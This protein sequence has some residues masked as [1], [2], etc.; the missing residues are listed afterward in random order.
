M[1]LRASGYVQDLHAVQK[2]K[3]L[4]VHPPIPIYFCTSHACEPKLWSA[5]LVAWRAIHC[6][7]YDCRVSNTG[8]PTSV[9]RRR[10]F[11]KHVTRPTSHAGCKFG[12]RSTTA[13]YMSYDLTKFDV[14]TRILAVYCNL[15]NYTCICRLRNINTDI[16][17][18]SA[19][20]LHVKC[21]VT[22]C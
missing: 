4:T 20:V 6:W 12:R 8:R 15:A 10:L 13:T 3:S 9:W 21:K 14:I 7:A 11:S 22:Q 1:W 18:L 2:W 16:T 17:S 5:N 19:V